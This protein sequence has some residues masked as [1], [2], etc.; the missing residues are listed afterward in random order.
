MK[1]KIFILC[2]HPD[3]D[4]F[5]GMV[6]AAYGESARKS[7]YAIRRLNIGDMRFDP[8]LHRGYKVTQKLEPDLLRFQKNVQWADHIVFVYPSWWSGMPAVLKGLFDRAWLPGFAFNFDKE[9]KQPIRHLAGKTGHFFIISGAHSPDEAYWCHCA[10]CENGVERSLMG[11][12][13][14]KSVITVFGLAEQVSDEKRHAWLKKV[15]TLGA[16]GK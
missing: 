15:K 7:G 13:G 2:G 9:T 8:V 6:T 3:A 4:S 12:A 11:L 10:N 1:K 14:V 5:S 16:K